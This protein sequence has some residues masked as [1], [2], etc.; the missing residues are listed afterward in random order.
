[1]SEHPFFQ[2]IQEEFQDFAD[3]SRLVHIAIRLLLATLLGGV[4]GFQREK[5]GKSAGLR[6][7]MLVT[8]GTA[9]YVLVPQLEGMPLSDMSRVI[10]GV[11]TGIGFLGAGAILKLTD[12]KEIHDLT[13]AAS[14]WL[15]AA[16]GIA[17]G[18]GRVG[19]AVIAT[20]FAF[21]VLEFLMRLEKKISSQD[22]P[23]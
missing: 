11:V 12:E 22:A 21:V 16:V 5:V 13:T 23:G 6:T 7:H 1:M 19:T 3:I 17:V 2:A 18:F 9:F 4:L 8:L 14:I 10:Q 15:A 20:L